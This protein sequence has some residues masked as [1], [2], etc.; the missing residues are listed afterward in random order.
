MTNNTWFAR[1]IFLCGILSGIGSLLFIRGDEKYRGHPPMDFFWDYLVLPLAAM[2]LLAFL[3]L[4]VVK[5]A[6]EFLGYGRLAKISEVD[7]LA[8]ANKPAALILARSYVAL[9]A[10]CM[11]I[12]WYS[13]PL[14][15]AFIA[16]QFEK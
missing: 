10:A 3:V 2:L 9:A 15:F 11:L 14:Q 13:I 12:Y 1:T 6:F 4:L 7:F 8:L 5:P 16:V